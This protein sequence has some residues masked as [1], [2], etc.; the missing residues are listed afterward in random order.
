[1]RRWIADPAYWALMIWTIAFLGLGIAIGKSECN[2]PLP[3][4]P[5]LA[6]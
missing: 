5:H 1:M 4:A 2:A 3:K 6:E